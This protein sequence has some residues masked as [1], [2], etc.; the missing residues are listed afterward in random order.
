MNRRAF[1]SLSNSQATVQ[2]TVSPKRVM[3]GDLTPYS[4]PWDR[5]TAAHL[6]RRACFGPS[7]DEI[8]EALNLGLT[9]TLDRLFRNRAMPNPPVMYDY[10]GDNHAAEGQTWVQ[11]PS[12]D[13]N[14]GR[15]LRSLRAWSIGQM[16]D[17][18]MHLRESMTLFWH[19]HFA[20][21]QNKVGEA[22]NAYQY[23]DTLR[24][25]A[26][27]NFKALV[28]KVTILPA[29][30]I[31]LDGRQNRKGRPNENY[32]RE[33]FE[34]FTIGKGP[35][36]G[37]G[38][39]TYFTETDVLAAAECL[40][41]WQDSTDDEEPGFPQVEFT[42]DRHEPSDKQFSDA[43]SKEVITNHGQDEYKVLIDMIFRQKQTAIYIVRKLYRWFLYYEIDDAVESTIIEPLAQQL[44]DEGYE[45]SGVLR[46]FLESDHFLNAENH[47]GLI[48]HPLD[49]VLG[50][51]K[52]TAFPMPPTSDYNTTYSI[53]YDLVQDGRDMQMEFLSPPDVA[54]WPAYYQKPLYHKIWI[55]SV[56]LPN[57]INFLKN[58]VSN[59][60]RDGDVRIE[61][62]L[63][64]LLETVED[65]FDPNVLIADWVER[66]L[67]QPLAESALTSLKNVLIPGLPDFEWTEEYVL[68]LQDPS[69]E[70]IEKS[71]LSK[72]EALLLS[73]L[74]L[75]EYQLS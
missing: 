38:N 45:L 39:Y 59:G 5:A 34:L 26:L 36:I 7:P 73:I 55:N 21:E 44:I 12:K 41:G 3:L 28:E 16:M 67:P 37:P 18:G 22:R 11:A 43:F 56:T 46:R 71:V 65:P 52:L 51:A 60:F 4:G 72:L 15:R 2:A 50:T 47:G 29:M 62:D 8:E 69:D 6:L 64:A 40:T 57:R 24:R 42:E 1:F 10:T 74:T 53:W 70:M 66:F 68:Y 31:Y 30:L 9:G 75:A 23:L 61:V 48:K 63:L 13:G 17:E 58:W 20:V 27:G 25:N 19:N 14:N 49:F 32:A 33:L 54:G 35:L